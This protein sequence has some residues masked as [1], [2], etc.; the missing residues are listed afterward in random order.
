[1]SRLMVQ[2]GADHIQGCE[3]MPQASLK[4]TAMSGFEWPL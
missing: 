4:P 2:E 3:R 1:V